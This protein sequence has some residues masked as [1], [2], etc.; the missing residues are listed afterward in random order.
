MIL[1][2]V[3]ITVVCAVP[4][5]SAVVYTNIGPGDAYSSSAY[6]VYAGQS[7]AAQFAPSDAG[8]LDTLRMP[9][10]RNGFNEPMAALLVSLRMPGADPNGAAIELWTVGPADISPAPGTVEVLQ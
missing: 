3:F 10:L 1:D 6:T 4:A 7:V 9:L 5:W 8:L 2:R